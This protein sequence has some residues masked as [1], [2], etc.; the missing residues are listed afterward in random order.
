[1]NQFARYRVWPAGD[2]E[3]G[4]V[5]VFART[6]QEAAD[7]GAS[8]LQDMSDPLEKMSVFVRREDDAERVEVECGRYLPRD[9]S[10]GNGLGAKSSQILELFK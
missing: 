7:E 10:G 6:A 2:L 1:M 8:A 5:F 9:S 3:D 4:G